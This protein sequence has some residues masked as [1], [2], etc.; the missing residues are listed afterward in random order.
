MSL[1]FLF[2][3]VAVSVSVDASAEEA[4]GLASSLRAAS[5]CQDGKK[6]K[7]KETN[8]YKKSPVS[9]RYPHSF[10]A[11]KSRIHLQKKKKKKK[12]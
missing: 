10:H 7:S 12:K 9:K 5:I 3:L 2:L 8:I 11:K 1:A 4:A 6:Q